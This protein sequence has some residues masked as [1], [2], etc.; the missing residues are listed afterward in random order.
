M[1][2]NSLRLCNFARYMLAAG[3][4]GTA[5]LGMATPSAATD[6]VSIRLDWAAQAYHAPLFYGAAK[7]YY[8]QQGINLKIFDGNNNTL[9]SVLSGHDTIVLSSYATMAQSIAQ[10]MPVI[11]IGGLM[12]RLPDA[13]IA[14]EGS[15]IRTPKDLEGKTGAMSP[16]SA[17]FKIFP[18]F[19]SA[20]GIDIKKIKVVQSAP[21]A[22]L[23]LLLQGQVD[24]AASWGFTQGVQVAKTKP[25]EKPILMAD[26]GINILSVGFI[27]TQD[28]AMQKRD[29]IRRFMSTTAQSYREAAKD[30]EG[31]VHAM[32]AERPA[33]QKDLL[34]DQ[35]KLFPH[36][37]HSDRTKGRPFGW[38][39][40][41]DWQDTVDNLQ[42]YF[43]VSETIAIDKL[44]TNEFVQ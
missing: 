10:G 25:L 7:G 13:I 36:Y 33:L 15:G 35:Y 6:N 17:I 9:Q 38:M 27:V 14:L 39:A 20:A 12:Q 37:L 8:A 5:A 31:A 28:A 2:R 32:L 29:L 23:T 40:R 19:V 24:F 44:Y 26:Y 11:G 41:E 21:G 42:K 1:R 3:M 16:S 43:E 18:A 34:V 4:I 22:N 30:P